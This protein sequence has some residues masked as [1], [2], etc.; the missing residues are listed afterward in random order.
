VI[1]LYVINGAQKGQSYSLQGETTTL[2]RSPDNDIQIKEDHLSRKHLKII[3]KGKRFFIVDLGST[4]GT[5]L[6]GE[7]IVPGKE[8]EVGEGSPIVV[9][10]T[11]I[12]LEEELS[13]DDRYS[14][15]LADRTKEIAMEEE[16]DAASEA[17]PMTH[18]KNM[19]FLYKVSTILM[20]SL[21]VNEIFQKIMDH[22]FELLKRIDRG[23]ILLI[24][25]ETGRLRQI[26]SRS[27]YET[28]KS[29]LNYSRTVVNKVIEQGT[30]VM[31]PD[32]SQASPESLSDSMQH[33]RSVMC[34]PLI[35]KSE[36]RGVIYV[37]SLSVPHGFRREDLYLL[38]ALSS[39][40]AIAIENALLYSNN[41]ARFKA[42]FD[43][44]TSGVVVCE[45]VGEGE[46][47]SLKYLNR[48]AQRIETINASESTGDRVS[49]VFPKLNEPDLLEVFKRVWKTGKSEQHLVSLNEDEIRSGWREYRVYRLP[50]GEI[51]AIFDDVT[52]KKEAELR[53]MALQE[54]LFASQKMESIGAL[55]GGMAHNFR[56]ILQAISGNVEYIETIFPKKPEVGELAKG[57]HN[58]IERGVDLINDLLHFSKKGD[59][60]QIADLDL[61]DVIVK[62]YDIVYRLFDRKIEIEVKLEQ[63]LFVKGNH[64]LLS[65]VFMNCFT[66][67]RD[68]MPDGGKLLIE[69]KKTDDK[70]V[71]IVS[72]TGHGMDKATL[73]KIFDPFF[74]LKEVG[75]GTG[76]GLSTARGIIEQHNGSI[77]VSSEPGKGTSVTITFPR[78]KKER[79]E[80]VEPN[81]Q[82][83]NG[84]G[85]RVLIVDDE[86]PVLD[87][88]TG[89]IKSLG[90]Q[91]ISVARATEAIKNYN[92]WAPDLVLMDRSMPEMDGVACIKR[93]MDMDPKSKI[94]VISGYNESGQNGI[95]ESVKNNIKGYIT[96]PCG[97]KELSRAL[98]DALH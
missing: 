43:H 79:I 10:K 24:D 32:T 75:M 46:D 25:H 3:T 52:E 55:A 50:S 65:Q 74:T 8:F 90:Y 97:M 67:A 47:F 91:T 45:V 33:V 12:C 29:K 41:E 86:R 70:V 53:Q 36:I 51:V 96:K 60:L 6:N 84:T 7:K 48:A 62:T 73:R 94:I 66:N 1:K 98:F 4:N 17:R 54:Q 89:L 5:L 83:M 76:L 38:T 34:V 18:F 93:I 78:A 2:G 39:S 57:I 9:G 16:A 22:M 63:G 49:E 68:A 31:M 80:I 85:Q 40:A 27:K 28:G 56:N 87:A 69:A 14:A 20:G 11:I 37:D 26:I 59:E 64:S 35:S 44:M 58:S 92:K 82:M 15:D 88:L 61:A 71:A 13:G 30:P 21:D 77:H 23:A 19:E 81:S 95:D 42:I 72:D